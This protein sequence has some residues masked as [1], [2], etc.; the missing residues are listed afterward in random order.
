MEAFPYLKALH[1]IFIVTWFAGL[2]YIVRLFIYQTEAQER[3]ESERAILTNQFKI[4]SKRLWYGI[5][6]PSAI[7]TLI[8][9]PSLIHVYFP[10]TDHPWLLAKL[11]F[12]F[13]LYIY[14]FICQRLFKE[15]Q[16]DQYK[17]SSNKLRVWNEVATLL[18]FA[19]VFLV[20]LQNIMSMWKGLAGLVLLSVLLMIGIKAYRKQRLK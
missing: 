6:W 19:I 1:I 11:A 13:L 15:L 12:V 7:L 8:F 20:I 14:H 4:M 2:F 9:G 10:I 17:W 18:L 5:T 16:N 3:E